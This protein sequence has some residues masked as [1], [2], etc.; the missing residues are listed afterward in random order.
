[1]MR[2]S[3]LCERAEEALSDAGFEPATLER[4]MYDEEEFGN[5]EAVFTLGSLRSRFLRDRAQDFLE[6]GSTAEP[7]RFFLVDDVE[8]A[9]GWKKVEEGLAKQYPDDLKD[10]VARVGA[11]RKELE[12]ALSLTNGP[13]SIQRFETAATKRGEHFLSLLK[14]LAKPS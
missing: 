8:V 6:L 12:H 3:Y 10:V 14:Q 11:K 13:K 1:M 7:R 2:R 5:A 9:M 4:E